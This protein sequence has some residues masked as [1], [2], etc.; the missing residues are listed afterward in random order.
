M[1]YPPDWDCFLLEDFELAAARN[2]MA[3]GVELLLQ[4]RPNGRILDHARLVLGGDK[5]IEARIRFDLLTVAQEVPEWILCYS[6]WPRAI[7]IRRNMASSTWIEVRDILAANDARVELP[8][9]RPVD[10]KEVLEWI[11]KL[12]EKGAAMRWS[13]AV[14]DDARMKLIL[15]GMPAAASTFSGKPMYRG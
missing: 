5:I 1:E 14:G 7:K 13:V 11:D 10:S 2:P 9:G 8:D 15:Q 3:C 6:I 12:P 4:V